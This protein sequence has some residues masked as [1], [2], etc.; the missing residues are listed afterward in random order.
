[1]IIEDGKGSGRTAGV[2]EKNRVITQADTRS[3]I[4][5]AIVRSAA[6]F[7]NS[8]V[9]TLTSD[10]PS[11]LFFI[12]NDG[13]AS[14]YI[15]EVLL[16]LGEST[17]GAGGTVLVS[18]SRNAAGG[19][20]LS[21]GTIGANTCQNFGSSRIAEATIRYGSEG[22]TIGTS[23]NSGILVPTQSQINTAA[24]RIYLP[25]GTSYALQITPPTGNTSLDATVRVL[26]G[27][28]QIEGGQ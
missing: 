20:I 5:A 11:G 3:E 10:N 1:M 4:N 19:T 26:F 2:D 8:P 27:E 6:F 23:P 16:C 15:E 9:I 28:D 25:Q 14:I 17:G 18:G 22:A 13:L 24:S 7:S 21:G 12:R